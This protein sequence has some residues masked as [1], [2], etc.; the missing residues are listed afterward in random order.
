[1]EITKGEFLFITIVHPFLVACFFWLLY[2]YLFMFFFYYY[3]FRGNPRGLGMKVTVSVQDKRKSRSQYHGETDRLFDYKE[4][5][6]ITV[7]FQDSQSLIRI[8]VNGKMVLA[9]EFKGFDIFADDAQLRLAQV[10]Q[11]EAENIVNI[12]NR[13]KVSHL[14]VKKYVAKGDS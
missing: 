11:V 12:K 8:F 5:H 9:E 1:M 14:Q 7:R 2:S 10:Y 6:N 4:W 3:Y 13:F